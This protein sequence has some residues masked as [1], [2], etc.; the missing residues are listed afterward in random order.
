MSIVELEDSTLGE[1]FSIG[2][3]DHI[4]GGMF[5]EPGA[6][7]KIDALFAGDNCFFR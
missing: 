5:A 4:I 6:A 3:G 2:T 7:A 1:E